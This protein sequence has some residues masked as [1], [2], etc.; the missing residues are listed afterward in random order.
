VTGDQQAAKAFALIPQSGAVLTA[1][2]Q[3]V[4]DRSLSQ[5]RI[6][7]MVTVNNDRD[8]Q[9][10]TI[11][12]RDRYP[13]RAVRLAEEIT[14]QSITQFEL[15]TNDSNKTK[16]FLKQ[17]MG[18]LEIDI[19]NLELALASL[20][21][22]VPDA[23]S[24]TSRISLLISEARTHLTNDRTM[25]NQLFS[26]YMSLDNSRP[27]LLQDAQIVDDPLWTGQVLTPARI[28]ATAIG[29]LA[30]LLI[31]VG[32]IILFEQNDNVLHSSVK[33]EQVTGLPTFITV[34]HLPIIAKQ[35]LWLN[36]HQQISG[37]LSLTKQVSGR[38]GELD[39]S[40]ETTY[41]SFSATRLASTNIT[42]RIEK[43]NTSHSFRLPEAFLTLGALLRSQLNS[44]G[45]TIRSLL[46]TS[47]EN[48]DGKTLVASQIAL[49]LARIGVKVVLVDANLRKP[50][51]HNIFRLS[52]RVGLSTLLT[53][54]MIDASSSQL[55]DI[56]VAPL[57]QTQEPHLSILPGG[58]AI[59]SAPELLSSPGMRT[60]LDQLSQNALVVVDSPAVLTSSESVILADECDGILVVVDAHRT[61][62]IKLNRSLELLKRVNTNV[63]GVVLNR[64]D[65]QN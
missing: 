32:L 31:I 25:Y 65:S 3:A 41:H 18:E 54:S 14:K 39:T 50:E 29:M 60:I 46:I 17:E 33:V 36:D 20:Q 51:I 58:P 62:A 48:G 57:I 52:N 38:R 61:E 4:G 55:D 8:S 12:V 49:G 1:T 16:Q 2:F 6:S 45:N 63:L 15:A 53:G 19:K 22:Q 56:I 44:N 9:F 40:E 5:S 23:F 59:D 11:S 13:K 30:G 37:D 34:E 47:P 7:S 27:V 64:A 35:A 10:V 28:L 43:N 26:S 42:D 21:S 24:T